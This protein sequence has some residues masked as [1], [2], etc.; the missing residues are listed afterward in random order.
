M[1]IVVKIPRIC[2]INIQ[3]NVS[4]LPIIVVSRFAVFIRAAKIGTSQSSGTIAGCYVN[5]TA[6]FRKS[7]V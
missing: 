7:G 1:N 2:L 3:M 6:Q 4:S 5:S